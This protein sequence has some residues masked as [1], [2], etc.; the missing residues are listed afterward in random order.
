M[1]PPSRS[2]LLAL[3]ILL[4]PLRASAVTLDYFVPSVQDPTIQL[5]IQD[6][7]NHPAALSRIF[8]TQSPIHSA[9]EI[10]IGAPFTPVRRLLIRPAST[11]GRATIVGDDAS[12]A[13]VRFTGGGQSGG[14]SFEDLDLVREVTNNHHLIELTYAFTDITFERC[15]IGSIDTGFPGGD[16]GWNVV[17][18]SNPVNVLFRN[19]LLFSYQPGTFERGIHVSDFATDVGS[20]FLYNNDVA[21]Y[22][23]YGIQITDL[24]PHAATLVLRNNVVANSQEFPAT[25]EPTAFRSEVTEPGALVIS[26]GNAAFASAPHVESFVGA[27]KSLIGTDLDLFPRDALGDPADPT[28][29]FKQRVWDP[30]QGYDANPVFFHLWPSG[31]LHD[32]P[33]DVGTTVTNGAPDALDKA[34]GDDIDFDPRPS[35]ADPGHTDRGADQVEHDNTGVDGSASRVLLAVAPTRNP[36]SDL[37]LRFRAATAGRLRAEVYDLAGRRIASIERPVVAGEIGEVR[38]PGP[39][40]VLQYRLELVPAVG[41]GAVVHGRAVVMR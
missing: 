15:R 39:Q 37:E 29:A 33:E 25:G 4:L 2:F 30:V 21:N 23:V 36:A 18:M 17:E 22:S 5:A 41:E 31:A 7:V 28:K 8:I 32:G 19:C 11:L 35:G 6:A 26:S 24:P 34:V 16:P 38:L 13:I 40:G 9:S 12:H 14:A 10:L 1:R 20:L 27:A 3:M